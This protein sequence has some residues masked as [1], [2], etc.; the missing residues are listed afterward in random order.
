LSHALLYRLNASRSITRTQQSI[1]NFIYHHNCFFYIIPICAIYS[2]LHATTAA[3]NPL[4]ATSPILLA[5]PELGDGAALPLGVEDVELPCTFAIATP[6][7][8]VPFLHWSSARSWA[9]ALNLMSAHCSSRVSLNTNMEGWGKDSCGETYVVQ[10]ASALAKLNNLYRRIH[11]IE[12]LVVHTRVSR[13]FQACIEM[14]STSLLSYRKIS[15]IPLYLPYFHTNIP[16]CK[17]HRV[18]SD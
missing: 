10:S 14:M 7:T 12:S 4:P 16:S 8:P 3:T 6:D 9:S 15:A 13:S 18:P 11:A 2:T 17:T 1:P 5:A